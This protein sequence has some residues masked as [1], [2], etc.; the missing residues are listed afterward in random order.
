MRKKHKQQMRIWAML[1]HISALLAWIL[2]FSLVFLGIPLYLPLNII[3]P[4]LIW[5]FK[6]SKYPWIDFQ[7]KESLNFQISLTFYILI[8][9]VISLVIVLASFGIA[10]ITNGAVDIKTILNSLLLVWMW[11]IVILMLFQSLLGIFAAKKAY[12]GEHYRYPL[13]I[14]FL[15]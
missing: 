7:G 15:S 11:L 9:I 8:L 10:V 4:L 12:K 3:A 14:R 6:K 2:L 5:R 1:C 13:T